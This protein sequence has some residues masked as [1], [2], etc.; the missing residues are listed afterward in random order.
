M[1]DWMNHFSV[2][3]HIGKY[4]QKWTDPLAWIGGDK[5]THLT[6]DVLP[7]K[8][9]EVGSHIM[10]PFEYVDKT[11][12]PVRKIPIVNRVG[13][14]VANKPGDVGA[15]VAGA[16]FGAGALG[17]GAGG[18]GA[19]AGA[20]GGSYLGETGLTSGEL[21]DGAG[22]VGGGSGADVGGLATLDSGAV[23]AEGAE[24]GLTTSYG[25]ASTSGTSSNWQPQQQQQHQR[26]A[27]RPIDVVHAV[28][29]DQQLARFQIEGGDTVTSSRAAKTPM[30]AG[31]QASM[32]ALAQQGASG[33]DRIS[34]NGVHIGAIKAL[35]DQISRL[36]AEAKRRG[37]KV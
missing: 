8:V 6:S 10:Q 37:I 19:G 25:S 17:G 28:P 24:P 14:I 9:N 22:V 26:P 34:Q 18:G 12:N 7:G 27:L 15:L 36:E 1:S 35:N 20:G 13:D 31:G 16:Y 21:T 5:W 32:V 11:I 33:R 29:Y 2:L 23:S 4:G 3:G 30:H